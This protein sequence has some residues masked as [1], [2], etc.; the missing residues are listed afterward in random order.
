[1]RTCAPILLVLAALL[2]L[3]AD[4]PTSRPVSPRWTETVARFA[5]ALQEAEAGGDLR[6]AI[7]PDCAAR[8]FGR[9]DPRELRLLPVKLRGVTLVSMHAYDGI[10]D[11]LAT[12]LATDFQAASG[13]PEELRRQMIPEDGEPMRRSN[14]TAARWVSTAL[15]TDSGPVGILVFCRVETE[16]LNLGGEAEGSSLTFVLVRGTPETGERITHV[17]YGDPLSR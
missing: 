4:R 8:E 10:P 2:S 17:V 16:S 12:D 13:V 9:A 14:Q 6:D 15:N 5:A 3:G 11:Q 7:A 1:M